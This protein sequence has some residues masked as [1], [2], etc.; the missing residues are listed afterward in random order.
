[1]TSGA[2][3]LVLG[4][5]HRAATGF[6]DFIV[7]ASNQAAVK[8]IDD[9]PHWPHSAVVVAGPAGSGKTHL[10]HVWQER[11]G[12]KWFAAAVLT[13]ADAEAVGQQR[14]VVIEDADRGIGSERALFHLMN[15]GREQGL[16]L[17]LTGRTPPGDWTIALPDLRSRL[18][19]APVVTLG[20][21][22]ENLL[23]AVLVKLLHDR[24]LPATPA[25]V[26]YLARHLERS[27]AAAIA[28][29]EALDGL[30]W[31][32]PSDITREVAKRALARVGLAG[33]DC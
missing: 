17:L 4:L 15:L 18:R 14:A 5:P 19:A 24:Q 31:D 13:E 3:Q 33:D 27:M 26:A 9:W 11:S 10:A 28:V 21:P 22:D 20:E 6:E 16:H 23:L 29:V 1:V 8:V 12:A 7:S 30:L 32:R 25:A 2:R